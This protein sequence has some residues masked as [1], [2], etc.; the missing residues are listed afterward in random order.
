MIQDVN[1]WHLKSSNQNEKISA[2][3]LRRRRRNSNN[4]IK[5][6]SK[7]HQNRINIVGNIQ[8]KSSEKNKRNN[9][10]KT[11][12]K[13]KGNGESHQKRRSF[14]PD[15]TNLTW[16]WDEN[17]KSRPKDTV[18]PERRLVIVQYTGWEDYYFRMT[19]IS[20]RANRAYAK[21]HNVDYVRMN[22]VAYG[23]HTGIHAPYNKIFI[24]RHFREKYRKNYDVLLLLDSDAVIVD[25]NFNALDL[26]PPNYLFAAHKIV[27][28]SS[29]TTWNINNGVTLW[30]LNHKE[31]DSV[32]G[33]W[34]S[35]C[36]DKMKR[37][38]GVSDQG[39]L[40]YGLRTDYTDNERVEKRVVW[41]LPTTHL[42]PRNGTFVTHFI[43]AVGGG[44]P[45]NWSQKDGTYYLPSQD[46]IDQIRNAVDRVCRS[47]P[48]TCDY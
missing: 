9:S 32:V 45:G 17:S 1:I 33:N 14:N 30:N 7:I 11:R 31:Y 39:P 36:K 34:A 22:G 16:H 43:R 29:N 23:T 35:R 6:S 44:L 8:R 5:T 2:K 28:R 12:K 20:S 24:L 4:M 26:L 27:P 15:N 21:M 46:R 47:W 13:K 38:L 10:K 48:N 19:D 37:G 25:F 18:A 40:H 41:A 3:A 42:Q